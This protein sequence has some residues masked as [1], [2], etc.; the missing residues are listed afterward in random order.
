MK[1]AFKDLTVSNK[2]FESIKDIRDL[3]AKFTD[4]VEIEKS[5]INDNTISGEV[6][7]IDYQQNTFFKELHAKIQDKDKAIFE[8]DKDKNVKYNL[9]DD[10]DVK[11][12]FQELWKDYNNSI[13]RVEQTPD[14]KDEKDKKV[15][16]SMK[17]MF[18]QTKEWGSLT[19]L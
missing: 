5:K 14:G 18:T 6:L 17:Y 11:K 8:L 9:I 13:K 10:A 1:N 2:T 12:K 15:F 3:A 4:G 16:Q 7:S 19:N